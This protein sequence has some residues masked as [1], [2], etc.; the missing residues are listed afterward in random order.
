[1]GYKKSKSQNQFDLIRYKLALRVLQ[2]MSRQTGSV[3]GGY[4]AA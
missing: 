3:L 4:W 1:M 2:T